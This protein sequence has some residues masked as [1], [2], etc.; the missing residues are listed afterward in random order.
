MKAEVQY[1]RTRLTYEIRRTKR[2]KTVSIAVMPGGS[3]VVTA[4]ARA[5]RARLNE[6]VR[7]KGTWIVSRLKRGSDLP[8]PLPEREFI[9]GEG[10][11][12]LG[13]QYRLKVAIQGVGAGVRLHGAELVAAG[14]HDVRRLLVDWYK[15]RA[16]EYLPLRAALWAAKLGVNLT[17][18][19]VSEPA[20]RWGSASRDGSLRINWRIMQA[21]V[22][23]VDYVLLHELTH[24]IHEDHSREFWATLGRIMP[25]YEERKRR[26]RE[27]GP[28]LV[29]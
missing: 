11:K 10:Y 16:R 12:Y 13:R 3:V 4:P 7:R 23:L 17:R 24:L 20:K 18:L 28:V 15:A 19:L 14:S 21:P 1:G 26:L 22:T 2:N 8:P 25:D 5:T 6:L 9:S 29:W 27:L